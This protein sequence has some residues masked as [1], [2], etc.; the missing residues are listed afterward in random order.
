MGR[1]V[2]DIQN[3]PVTDTLAKKVAIEGRPTFGVT[4]TVLQDHT[5]QIDRPPLAAQDAGEDPCPS[6][7]SYACT[8]GSSASTRIW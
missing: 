3:A 8:G 2:L 4:G 1:P 7:Y 6:N 5:L